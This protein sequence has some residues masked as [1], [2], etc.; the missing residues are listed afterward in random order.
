MLLDSP[1]PQQETR[2][3][4][5]KEPLSV[6]RSS[7]RSFSLS[8]DCVCEVCAG[9]W[10]LLFALR[11]C[12]PHLPV[13]PRGSF[14]CAAYS[15]L[16]IYCFFFINVGFSHPH[17]KDTTYPPGKRESELYENNNKIVWVCLHFIAVLTVNSKAQ[18]PFRRSLSLLTPHHLQTCIKC[19][20][21]IY[22][23]SHFIQT[24]C[25][26]TKPFKVPLYLVYMFTI[27]SSTLI[28]L[29]LEF[30]IPSWYLE[31]YRQYTVPVKSKHCGVELLIICVPAVP[32]YQGYVA[33]G[34]FLYLSELQCLH[35]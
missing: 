25:H 23:F 34:M 27:E 21:T 32:I 22:I 11:C 3:P 8:S 30:H 9:Q 20:W 18:T 19:S 1:F 35:L 31:L 5:M 28:W 13:I 14:L 7:P 12:P 15:V 4:E 2:P 24:Y 17:F 33:L 10:K 6:S 26:V 16:S 29:P